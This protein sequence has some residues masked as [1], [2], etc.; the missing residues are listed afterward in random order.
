M[1]FE[2]G[3]LIMG[4]NVCFQSV[5]DELKCLRCGSD[6]GVCV[7]WWGGTNTWCRDQVER[8]P[9]LTFLLESLCSHSPLSYHHLFFNLSKMACSLSFSTARFTGI[10]QRTMTAK[11]VGGGGGNNINNIMHLH[12]ILCYCS[13]A[14]QRGCGGYGSHFSKKQYRRF[15]TLQNISLTER[16]WLK[17]ERKAH[18]L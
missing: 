1:H 15:G 10:L 6:G 12:V 17:K 9:E 8:P 16:K 11:G 13:A 2:A 4:G 14:Q 3:A 7:W 5:T 18:H